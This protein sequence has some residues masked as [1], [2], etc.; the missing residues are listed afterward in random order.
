VTS[1]ARTTSNEV[2][3]GSGI[4]VIVDDDDT[5]ARLGPALGVDAIVMDLDD[6]VYLKRDYVRS[7]FEAIG[8]WAETELG[9][10]DFAQRAWAAYDAGARD[11][12]FD[13]VLT[14]CG[15]RS[16]DAVI[17]ALV[18]RYR[19]HAPSI[20]LAPD[21]RRALERWYGQVG[22]ATVT[23][24][25]ISSQHAKV[26][27]LGLDQWAP[28][29][30]CTQSLGPGKAKPHPAGFV[31]VQEKLGV[32]GKGCVYVAD[33]PINDFAGPKALG[34]RT[35]RVRR[36]LGLYWSVPSGPDV[37]HEITSLDQLEDALGG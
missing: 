34:W 17:T 11:T 31:Q 27:A 6:T 36:R 30:V 25:A 32:D 21:A 22:L 14:E 29:V 3:V 5:R 13:Q 33:D 7:G 26:R 10:A 35:V 20:S 37:D 24:G 9:V 4:E 16:D 28:L 23:D 15:A 19:T 8:R 2:N 18:A 12:V 1:T